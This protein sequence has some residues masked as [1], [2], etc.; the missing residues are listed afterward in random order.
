MTKPCDKCGYNPDKLTEYMKTVIPISRL[1]YFRDEAFKEIERL[2][3]RTIPKSM[4]ERRIK[5]IEEY[6]LEEKKDKA[7]LEE[8]KGLLE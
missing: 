3:K 2:R 7:I 4:I 5:A 1:D 6:P 8:L